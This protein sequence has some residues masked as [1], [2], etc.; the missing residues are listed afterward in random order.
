M[1]PP[2]LVLLSS[3]LGTGEASRALPTDPTLSISPL[4]W[5]KFRLC[6]L[7]LCSIGRGKCLL[8]NCNPGLHHTLRC[9]LP[10][11]GPA[12]RSD[13]QCWEGHTDPCPHVSSSWDAGVCAGFPRCWQSVCVRMERCFSNTLKFC[14]P[15]FFYRQ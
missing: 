14:L 15:F 3:A 8:M 7:T 4:P 13:S 2:D 11:C 12:A 10:M 1:T 9:C 5:L 6:V